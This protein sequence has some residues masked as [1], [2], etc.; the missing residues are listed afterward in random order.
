M[1]MWKAGGDSGPAG[2]PHVETLLWQKLS[3]STPNG[4]EAYLQLGIS[5]YPAQL[6]AS[7]WLLLK[8]IE[9]RPELGRG[10]YRL[11]VAYDRTGDPERQTRFQ[12]A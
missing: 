1:A 11:G 10:H 12:C 3:P 4:G 8:A 6:W 2:F 9:A 5:L 7:H